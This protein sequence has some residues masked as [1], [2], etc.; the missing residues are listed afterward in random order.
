MW[1]LRYGNKINILKQNWKEAFL[2]EEASKFITT[3]FFS[4]KENNSIQIKVKGQHQILHLNCPFL[5]FF[6]K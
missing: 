2:A 3:I 1:M 6:R 4:Q 5:I